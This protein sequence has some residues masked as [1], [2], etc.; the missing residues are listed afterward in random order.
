MFTS[1][2]QAA[3]STSP[4]SRS[5]DY[6]G[7]TSAEVITLT[8]FNGCI[9]MIG[10]VSNIL[11]ILAVLLTRQ[12][13]E[14]CTAVLLISLS[15]TDVIICAV[16]QLMNIVDINYGSSA[17]TVRFRLGF[18]FFLASLNGGPLHLH[19]FPVSLPW[20]DEHEICGCISVL[21]PVVPRNITHLINLHKRTDIHRRGLHH[22]SLCLNRS[23]PHLHV[24]HCQPPNQENQQSVPGPRRPRNRSSGTNQLQWWSWKWLSCC[25]VGHQLFF[26]LQLYRTARRLSSAT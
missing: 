23:S 8:V 22:G 25:C 14:I 3:N 10:T 21:C 26:C 4:N 18:G 11:V 2:T 9:A 1:V 17:I 15:V 13:Q 5:F 7:M 20:L 24:L 6:C 16:Y 12:L 19:S